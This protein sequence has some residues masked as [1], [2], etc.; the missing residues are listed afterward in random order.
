MEDHKFK[1]P[2]TTDYI[3]T[4]KCNCGSETFTI[5]YGHY[6]VIAKCKKCEEEECIY[7]G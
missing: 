1:Y 5:R 4:L 3:T 2:E 7:S 6:E